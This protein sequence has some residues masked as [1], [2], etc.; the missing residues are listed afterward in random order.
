MLKGK[1][2]VELGSGRGSRC[3]DF[4]KLVLDADFRD[5]G[6]GVDDLDCQCD[7]VRFIQRAPVGLEDVGRIALERHQHRLAPE[8]G[9]R[10]AVAAVG[11]DEHSVAGWNVYVMIEAAITTIVENGFPEY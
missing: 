1:S 6:F 7:A 8:R 3:R 2:V 5:A 9:K 4:F 10:I 11:R